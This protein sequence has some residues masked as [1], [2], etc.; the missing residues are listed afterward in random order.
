MCDTLLTKL[1]GVEKCTAGKLIILHVLCIIFSRTERTD[2]SDPRRN[3]RLYKRNVLKLNWDS[4]LFED[5]AHDETEWII[6]QW[7]QG[8]LLLSQPHKEKLETTGFR[9]QL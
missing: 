2:F 9:I 8:G 4:G 5:L 3:V 1:T 6:S 7:S